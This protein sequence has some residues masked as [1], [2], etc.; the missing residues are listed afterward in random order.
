MQVV[1]DA[2]VLIPMII[3]ASRSARLFSR[4]E[5]AGHEVVISPQIVDEVAEKMRT[6]EPLRRWLRLSDD[7]IEAFVNDLPSLCRMVPSLVNA[8]G[9]VAADPK[10]DKIVA[11]AIEGKADYIVSEDKHLRDLK[12]YQGIRIMNR[13]EFAAELDRLGV[14]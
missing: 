8:D 9:A 2:D 11:A 13:D 4:L 12:E 1:F 7:K 6:K 3:E 5:A 14:E 10:D